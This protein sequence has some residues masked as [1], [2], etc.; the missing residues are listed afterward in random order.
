[1]DQFERLRP[2]GRLEQYSTS[3]HQAGFYLN[4]A[5]TATYVLPGSFNLSVKDYVYRACEP[6][7]AEHPALS[8]IPA[9]DDTQQ[10]YFVRLPQMDL[11]QVV[12][13]EQRKNGSLSTESADGEPTP[14]LDLQNLLENQHNTP[15]TAPNAY[16]RLCILTDPNDEQRFTAAFVFHHA[17]GDGTSGKAFHQTFLQALDSAESENRETKSIIQSPSTPL[18]PNIEQIH[19]MPLSFL[20][21]AKKIF[22]AKI[23]S[24]R[25]PG[26]WSGGKIQKEGK[27]NV[28]LVPFSKAQVT[29]LRKICR[30]EQTTITALLQTSFARA[31]FANLP[32]RYTS[33]NCTGAISCRRWLPDIIT[34]EVMGVYVG[35]IEES[36]TRSSTTNNTNTFPWPEARRSKATI[37]AAVQRQGR[38]AGPNLLKYVSDFQ[39]E[40]CLSKVG[41]ERDKSFE[42]SNVGVLSCEDVPGKPRIQGMVFSQCASV[43]G[44]AIGVSVVTGGDGC[45]VLA[46]TW[47]DGIVEESLIEGAVRFL[48]GELR[49]LAGLES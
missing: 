17:L 4:V 26:L 18:L 14:D 11:D 29:S 8:A 31:L 2:V 27:T 10:P 49:G 19:P 12:S 1:M 13:F 25:D 16:W 30:K 48:K 45:M 40:L 28:R 24:P 33:L 3:R 37:E 44:N 20:F 41:N 23:Y 36:Y 38:D 32:P 35:D 6:L 7:I 46:V 34:D 42:V 47:Q 15:F 5:V 22:Q 39:Q 21:L 43:I 9:A